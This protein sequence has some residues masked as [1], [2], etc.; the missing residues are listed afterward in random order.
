MQLE[1]IRPRVDVPIQ[2]HLDHGPEGRPQRSRFGD[3]YQCLVNL[4][5]ANLYLKPIAREA[6]VRSGAKQGDDVRIVK[7]LHGNAESYDIRVMTNGVAAAPVARQPQPI[8]TNGSAP[9]QTVAIRPDPPAAQQP[10]AEAPVHRIEKLLEKCLVT[11]ARAHWR[12]YQNALKQGV[13]ID[14][15]NWEDARCTATSLFIHLSENGGLR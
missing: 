12:A 11:A 7:H 9:A 5:Q 8:R 13:Q 6:L 10:E 2:V 3:D 1:R 14:A 15:P 4:G